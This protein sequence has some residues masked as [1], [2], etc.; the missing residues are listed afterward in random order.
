VSSY[1]DGSYQP[2][3]TVTLNYQ[4]VPIDGTALPQ[5]FNF[6]LTAPGFAYYNYIQNAAPTGTIGFTIPSNAL[7]GNLVVN[8]HV[9]GSLTAGSCVPTSNCTGTTGLFINPHP[10]VL[11]MELGAGSGVTV[12]WLILLILVLV[13]AIVLF[14]VLR[15]RGGPRGGTGSAP[16]SVTEPMS[17]AAP[18]PSSPPASE[19]KAPDNP[20]ASSGDSG[21]P[22]LPAPPPGAS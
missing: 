18:A 7:A 11:S 15:R 9:T 10:S 13:V 19:W 21:Q 17:P 3:Q 2:G 8:L 20:P 5:F 6:E 12:G 4:V 1:S 14:L 22:P 16:T